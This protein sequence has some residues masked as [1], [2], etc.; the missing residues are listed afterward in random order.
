M[1]DITLVH[2]D[3]YAKWILTVTQ[4]RRFM[5]AKDRLYEMADELNLSIAEVLPRPATPEELAIVHSQEYIID[6]ALA[7]YTREWDGVRKDL[8]EIAQLMA[9]G[10]IVALNELVAG[11]TKLAVNFAGAKHH[12]QYD[13][14]SGFCVF[15]DLA[16]AAK[17]LTD[18]VYG[19][20]KRVAVFD[21]DVHHGDGTESLLRNN[22]LAL[23]Y[24]VHQKGIFPGT[25]NQS[26]PEDHAYNMPL[27][28]GDGDREFMK[29][30]E[31]FVDLVR[32][33]K[34]DYVFI[35]GGADGH[36]LD[37]LGSINYSYKGY[38]AAMRRLRGELP[39]MPMLYG[40]AGGYRPDDVTPRVWATAVAALAA[41]QKAYSRG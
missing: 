14:S 13:Y 15:A 28:A 3:E 17:M 37:P 39:D 2:S 30:V 26:Y 11:N 5:N 40:G 4:G 33:F 25:G 41:E 20:P 6:E 32:E 16:M 34:A 31:E 27:R 24:S 9:G 12:A 10:T 18:G 23:T 1:N 36:K 35:A 21:F 29:A 19:D 8:G 7:G 38:D 22:P